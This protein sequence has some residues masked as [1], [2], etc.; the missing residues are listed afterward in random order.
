[1]IAGG[2]AASAIMAYEAAL[3]L[4]RPRVTGTVQ[5]GA[6]SPLLANIY[7]HPFDVALTSQGLRLVRFMDDFVVMCPSE[8]EA[9]RAYELV[10]RQLAVLRLHL[11][12]EKTHIVHYHEGFEFLGQALAPRRRGPTLES[13][14]RSFEEADQRLRAALR[15][16]RRG[17]RNASQSV[18]QRLRRRKNGKQD[19]T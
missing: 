17:T 16:A 5:G 6:L 11:N 9:K 4:Q 14:L 18:Q 2:V 10:V 1:M 8:A 13:G 19:T 15:D 12:P 7:L 3:R